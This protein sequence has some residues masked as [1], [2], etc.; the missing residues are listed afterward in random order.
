MTQLSWEQG[1]TSVEMVHYLQ[2]IFKYLNFLEKTSIY[3][4]KLD[5]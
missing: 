3:D 4:F 1:L 5:V 2:C